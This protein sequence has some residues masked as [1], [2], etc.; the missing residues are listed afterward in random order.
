M[1]NIIET[2]IVTGPHT[3]RIR[4]TDGE[5]ANVDFRSAIGKG[6]VFAALADPDFF[7]QVTV[8]DDGRYI[9]WPGELDFCADAIRARHPAIART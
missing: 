6:G 9:T 3:V 5:V 2:A 7:A 8:S 1:P 4:Y